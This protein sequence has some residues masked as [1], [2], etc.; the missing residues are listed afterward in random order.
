MPFDFPSSPAEDQIFS[1]VGG[2]KYIYKAPRWLAQAA[3]GGASVTISDTA[4]V[5]PTPGS[6]WFELDSGETYIW[7]DDGTSTQWVQMNSGVASVGGSAEP[8]TVSMF[9]RS[10]SPIGW[11]KANGAA[12]SRTS[13]AT[14]FAAIGTTFGV[15]DGSTTFNIP[16][17]RGEFLRTWD[18]S[19]GIDAGRAFGSAQI[20]ALKSHAHTFTG[21]AL[22]D[23]NHTASS[24]T[25]SADHTH[26]TGV[27][28]NT[29]TA[30]VHHAHGL[31]A[32]G[33]FAG[34]TGTN[35]LTGAGGNIIKHQ[36]STNMTGADHYH[37][38]SVSVASGGISANHTHA[39][40]NVAVGAGTPSGTIGNFGGTETRPRNVALLACIKY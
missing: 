30:S 2:P 22:A 13:Y 32:G 20:E 17:L 7:Y 15:G 37:Y 33:I 18:D 6:L 40:T 38:F 4:P 14:L 5:S 3:G 24:G 29:G 8:G 10:T 34:D 35:W 23:H 31:A 19:R 16:D 12:L 28:G 21:N 9:A 27:A 36:S 39:I 26:T 25:V 1:P 11:V